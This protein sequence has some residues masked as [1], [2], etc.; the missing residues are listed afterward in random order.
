MAASDTTERLPAQA[1]PPPNG[2]GAVTTRFEALAAGYEHSALQP[3]LYV[4]AQQHVLRLAQRLIPCPRRILDVSCGTGRLLRQARQQHPT[5]VLVG[6]DLAWAMV[7]NANAATPAELA[8]LHVRAAAERLPFAAGSFDLVVATLALRHWRDMAAGIAE[9]DRVLVGG[10]TLIVGDLFAA[11]PRQSPLGALWRRRQPNGP[12]ELS[13]VIAA[14]GLVVVACQR[15]PW[16][17]LPDLQIVA[18]QKSVADGS[19]Q[20]FSPAGRIA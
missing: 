10:G 6:V 8:I 18:A 4:P 5:A 1:A 13:N 12:A 15:M 17:G 3:I 11:A 14:L 16:I 9:I 2:P 19:G 20:R 7:A